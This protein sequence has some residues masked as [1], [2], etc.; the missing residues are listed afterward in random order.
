[1]MK[2]NCGDHSIE[3]LRMRQKYSLRAKIDLTKSRIKE[4]YDHFNGQVY[5]AFSGG[6]DSTVLL[7]IVRSMYPDVPAVYA[8]TGLEYPEIR[9]FVRSI[10]NVVWV[11]PKMGFK[12]VIEKYGFPLVSKRVAHAIHR[13]KTTKSEFNKQHYIT[14]IS[15][16]GTIYRRGALPKKWHVLINAPFLCGDGCCDVMK[17]RPF[18]QYRKQTGR[19]AFT[20]VMAQDSAL[21]EEGYVREGCNSYDK[22]TPT[23]SPMAFWMESDVW[24][25]IRQN[26][27]PYCSIYDTGVTRTG[28]MFCM[29][30]VHLERGENRFQRMKKSHPKMWDYCINVLNLKLPLSYIGVPFE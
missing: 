10:P 14:G 13:I 15:H 9:E 2:K 21:R 23:S 17:K 4:W 27:L 26:N 3:Q 1:M 29:F 24:D 25:Y 18:H 19:E 28:C 16:A 6:K 5:V 20:G 30:G 12:E 22:K 7:H 8:D 11:R